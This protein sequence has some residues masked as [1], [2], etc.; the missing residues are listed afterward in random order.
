MI[1]MTLTISIIV[2]YLLLIG[3]FAY[4]FDRVKAFKLQD[5]PSKSKFTVVIPFRNEALHLP[6]LLT[7]I[8][9]LNY[10]KSLYEVILVND[11][12]SDQSETLVETYINSEN[13][14]YKINNIRLVKNNRQSNSPKKDAIATAIGLSKFNWIITSDADCI[15]PKYWLDTF[16]EYLQ[17]YDCNCIVG[18]V[19]FTNNNS[20]FKRFQNLD[21]LSLQ[22]ATIGGFG[23]KQPFMCNGANFAYKKSV[24]TALK[25]FNENNHIASGDDIFLLEKFLK[26]NSKNVHYLKSSKA[27]VLTHPELDL[28]SLIQQ[29]LRWASKTSKYN[30]WFAKLV[31]L[32]V[33]STN[34]TCILLIPLV[35]FQFLN[36]KTAFTL[37]MIKVCID[38]LLL[39]K[40]TRFFNQERLLISYLFSSIIYP[41]F[42]VYVAILS[43]F[44]SYRWK[45]RTFKK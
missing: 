14:K 31:G 13:K 40:A 7:S 25:G 21:F 29:R 9:E 24:Y 26:H 18:P 35:S 37:F 15:L 44:K 30:N 11:E 3:L 12:S 39:F 1:V 38:F 43:L 42:S 8:S 32:V 17:S 27:L 10:P 45:G 28:K 23:V 19:T 22:G 33:F 41:I 34:L 5:L 16:D 36:L 2:I 6:K 20:F 4:G